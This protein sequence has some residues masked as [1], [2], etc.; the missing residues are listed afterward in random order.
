[1]ETF[2][3][4]IASN[5]EIARKNLF[6]DVFEVSDEEF[7]TRAFFGIF[8]LENKIE[9]L[10]KQLQQMR[11]LAYEQFIKD[12][13]ILLQ[14]EFPVLKA[15]E[16]EL[17]ILDDQDHFVRE[18]LGG[19]SAYTDWNGGIFFAVLPNAQ[20]H[21]NLKS[22]ITHEYHHYWRMHTLTSTEENQ[23]LLDRLILE[24]LAE[25]F[26]E[27]RLG[28]DYLGPYRDALTEQQALFLWETIY[29]PY[30]HERG[31][32]TD[33]YMFG[34]EEKNL[35]FWGG[36]AIGYYLVK[37]YLEKNQGSTIEEMTSLPSDSFLL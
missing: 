5:S 8:N 7:Q 33:A 18:K 6:L 2:L 35:P 11:S 13:L 31:A 21:S 37:W 15:L 27:I 16:F 4:A 30:R 19:V 1:M 28:E 23:T 22:V 17:F 25:H 10:K 3:E 26:V 14:T 24:G 12:E 36:Y 29:R 9:I 34:S 20:V 32:K